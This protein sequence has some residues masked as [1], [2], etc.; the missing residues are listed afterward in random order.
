MKITKSQ[1]KDLISEELDQ[2]ITKDIKVHLQ[3]DRELIRAIEE[4][5]E[6]IDMLDISID[7]LAA[8]TT[9][10]SPLSI[11]AMQGQIGRGARPKMSE[12]V[13]EEVIKYLKE[14]NEKV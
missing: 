11:S 12:V 4:L 14:K 2:S 8:A 10:E 9:G 1:L 7:Y 3:S 5:S 13:K 6:K